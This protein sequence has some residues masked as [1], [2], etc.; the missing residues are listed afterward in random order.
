MSLANLKCSLNNDSITD[1]IEVAVSALQFFSDSADAQWQSKISFIKEQISLLKFRKPHYSSSLMITAF[2]INSYSSSAY[3]ALRDQSILSLPNS[4][5]LLKVTNKV[6]SDV[7]SL[8]TD[9]LKK[10]FAKLSQFESHVSITFDEIY[11]AKRLEYSRASKSVLGMTAEAQPARSV[12]YLMVNSVCGPFRDIISMTPIST[13]SSSIILKVFWKAVQVLSEIGFNIIAAISD[14]HSSNRKFF[15]ELMNGS[16]SVSVPNPFFDNSPIYLLFD[17][18]HN[19]KNFYNN[20][21]N[22]SFFKYP[23]DDET[24]ECCMTDLRDLFEEESG[25]VLKL[26]PQIKERFI[27]PSNLERMSM[28]PAVSIFHEKTVAAINF[29]DNSDRNW[30]GTSN[31][32]SRVVKVFENFKLQNS[33]GWKNEEERNEKSN[34][35]P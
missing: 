20:L 23:E 34:S 25:R 12:L 29:Y 15:L 33:C 27:N 11:I 13:I 19:L 2:I 26:A 1:W 32:I 22:K 6:N 8:D 35:P 31:L 28:K 16:W 9:Y 18:V 30:A 10:R 24:K 5:T 4:R 3:Q 21:V 14:N 17:P 7:A